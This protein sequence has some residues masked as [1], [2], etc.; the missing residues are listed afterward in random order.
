MATPDTRLP[1]IFTK[2]ALINPSRDYILK[3]NCA[4]AKDTS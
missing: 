2:Y 4:I 1:V 3:S